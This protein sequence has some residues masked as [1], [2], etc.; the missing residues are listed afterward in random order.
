[1][2]HPG[3]RQLQDYSTPVASPTAWKRSSSAPRSTPSRKPFIESADMFFLATS[4]DQGQPSCSYR[5]GDR[6][7]CA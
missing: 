7:S 6:D 1:M 2:Y 3:Q 5:G 4:D